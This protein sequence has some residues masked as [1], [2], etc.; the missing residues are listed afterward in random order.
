MVTPGGT[1]GVNRHVPQRYATDI[2]GS[3]NVRFW[4]GLAMALVPVSVRVSV[5]TLQAQPSLAPP[6]GCSST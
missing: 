1:V 3:A 2:K 6:T 4:F 5:T